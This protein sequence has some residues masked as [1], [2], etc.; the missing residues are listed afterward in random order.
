MYGHACFSNQ[1]LQHNLDQPSTA[2]E[3][4]CMVTPIGGVS[5]ILRN[6]KKE[7]ATCFVHYIYVG[8]AMP[9]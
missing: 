6:L 3:F 4:M 5:S 1:A 7:D 9:L 2:F 8:C